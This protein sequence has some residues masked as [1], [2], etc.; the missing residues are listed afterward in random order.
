MNAAPVR[1]VRSVRL[2]VFGQEMLTSVFEFARGSIAFCLHVGNLAGKQPLLVRVQS[3]CL[4]GDVL[5]SDRCQCGQQLRYSIERVC[6]ARRG[7]IVYLPGQDG[8]GAGLVTLVE[9]FP[10]TD[11][12]LTSQE[13]FRRLGANPD[14]RDYSVAVAAL[15]QLGVRYVTLLTDN[16]AKALALQNAGIRVH[17]CLPTATSLTSERLRLTTTDGPEQQS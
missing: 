3:A 10:L 1:S 13:A 5:G 11:E 8:R 6:E 14:R 17:A 7:V 15:G 2:R 12:G 4:T 9:S 16:P